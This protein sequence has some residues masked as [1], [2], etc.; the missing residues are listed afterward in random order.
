M[1]KYDIITLVLE[2]VLIKFLAKKKA[3]RQRH[4]SRVDY[5]LSL[6]LTR[7]VDSNANNNFIIPNLNQ[8]SSNILRWEASN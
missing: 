7:H 1:R 3:P 4:S 8:R 2:N 5:G 6:I